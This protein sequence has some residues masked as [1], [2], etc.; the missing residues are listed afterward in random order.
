MAT[1]ISGETYLGEELVSSLTPSGDVTLYLW[2]M[3]CLKSKIG[4]PT[5][6]VDVRGEEVL[7]F[8]CHGTPGHW[9]DRGYDKLGAGGSHQDFPEGLE[10]VQ[11]QISWS[12]AQIRDRGQQLLEEAERHAEASSLDAEMVQAATDAIEA[13]LGNAGDLR[14]QAVAQG[15]IEA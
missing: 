15:L 2:P 8:D 3:R 6:G 10:D 12:L 13:H 14:S 4:G 5:F 9:H 7:R 1:T 11:Q